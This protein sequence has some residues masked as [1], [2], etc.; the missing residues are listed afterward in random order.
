MSDTAGLGI[1]PGSRAR[2]TGSRKCIEWLRRHLTA[3]ELGRTSRPPTP[4]LLLPKFPGATKPRGA[5]NLLCK[6]RT[7]AVRCAV[8]NELWPP[9]WRKGNLAHSR[10]Y[11]THAGGGARERASYIASVGIRGFSSM[12]ARAEGKSTKVYTRFFRN[13]PVV[14]SL[15]GY[16]SLL[17][18]ARHESCAISC[19]YVCMCGVPAHC[20]RA[21]HCINFQKL[22]MGNGRVPVKA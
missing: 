7:G 17:Y 4:A 20:A 5:R 12:R 13:Q 3:S 10:R 14:F 22:L 9:P 8:C 21:R 16:Y 18:Y 11:V 1:V 19:V 15:S 2:K 6:Y